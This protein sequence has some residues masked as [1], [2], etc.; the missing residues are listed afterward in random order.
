MNLVK[1]IKIFVALLGITIIGKGVYSQ[2][3]TLSYTVDDIINMSI[4]ELINI[5]ITAQKREESIEKVPISVSYFG[6]EEITQYDIDGVSRLELITPG[7]RFGQSG[8][9][10]RLSIR[11]TRTNDIRI[12]SSQV[13]GV[14]YDGVYLPSTTMVMVPWV[15]AER[16]EVLRGPQGTLYGRNTFGGAINVWSKLPDESFSAK[17]DITLGNY[18]RKKVDT[19]VNRALNEIFMIRVS[20]LGELRDGYVENLNSPGASDDLKDERQLYMRASLRCVPSDKIE[21]ILRLSHWEQHINGDGAFGYMI[22]G[23]VVDPVS[24]LSDLNGDFVKGNPRNGTFG[25]DSDEGPYKVYRDYPYSRDIKLHNVN[26]DLKIDLGNFQIKSISA[27]NSF[28]L[29]QWSDGDLSNRPFAAEGTPSRSRD[30]FQEIQLMSKQ[31]EPLQWLVGAY[32]QNSIFGDLK[33]KRGAY[34]WEELETT[35]DHDTDPNT[36]SRTTGIE[37]PGYEWANLTESELAVSSVFANASYN[38]TRKI[39]A[40]AGLRYNSERKMSKNWLLPMSWSPNIQEQS[41]HS[42]TWNHV[43]WK[44]TAEYGFS[45]NSMVYGSVSNGFR[46]GGFNTAASSL[47]S[48]DEEIVTAYE[49]G[50]KRAGVKYLPFFNV[51]AFYNQYKAM[52][53][54]ELLKLPESGAVLTIT[55]NAGDMS[56]YGIESELI[57]APIKKLKIRSTFAYLHTE[58]G[59]YIVQNPFDL[60]DTPGMQDE[61]FV[62]LKGGDIPMSPKYTASVQL[63]YLYKLSNGAF[64]VP[65]IQSYLSSS[66][67]TNDI[68]APGTHQEAYSKTDLKLTWNSPSKFWSVGLY[69]KNLENNAVLNRTIVSSSGTANIFANYMPPRTFGIEMKIHLTSK[70][71][72]K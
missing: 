52:Q 18:N 29:E 33:D 5:K 61:G 26:F 53:S 16:V 12:G 39:K 1:T 35:T 69:A 7:L 62:N 47:P 45:E 58:F 43:T 59:N 20:A 48:Y 51:V 11:G 55:S 57:W 10:A 66:F 49:F 31:Q 40:S 2:S 46:A 8:S 42:K 72:T 24:G 32:Y 36:P 68:M 71:N 34:I 25:A 13:I 54:Q 19:Y 21:A 15:D 28:D 70:K 3:D 6:K 17:A 64:I 63:S 23:S 37:S 56:A 67:Y 22:L 27:F 38:I 60:G 65:F 30:L 50:Y 9:D 14:F 41:N 44:T 4:E